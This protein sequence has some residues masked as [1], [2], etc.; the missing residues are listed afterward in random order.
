MTP[1]DTLTLVSSLSSETEAFAVLCA[2][3]GGTIEVPH[4]RDRDGREPAHVAAGSHLNACAI[5]CDRCGWQVSFI[6][7]MTLEHQA[8]REETANSSL[9]KQ[10]REW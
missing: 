9:D 1:Q 8:L 7:P 2:T 10:S 3:C 4:A 6:Y 5:T